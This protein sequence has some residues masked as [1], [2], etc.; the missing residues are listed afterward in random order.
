MSILDS[1]PTPVL[2]TGPMGKVLSLNQA[3][4]ALISGQESDWLDGSMDAFFPASVQILLQTQIWPLLLHQGKVQEVYLLI[5]DVSQNEIP[6]LASCQRQLHEG[7]DAYFWVF[8]VMLE[9]SLFEQE[10]LSSRT[11][12]RQSASELKLALDASARAQAKL[13]VELSEHEVAKQGLKQSQLSLAQ[14]T[15]IAKLGVWRN[16]RPDPVTFDSIQS[17]WSEEMYVLLGYTEQAVPVPTAAAFLARVHPDDRPLLLAVA[18]KS[19]AEKA[20]WQTEYRLIRPDGIECLVEES[21]EYIFEANGDVKTM[22]GVVKDVTEKKKAELYLALHRDQLEELVRHRTSELID[23]ERETKSVNRSLHMLSRC[24]MVVVHATDEH[25]LLRDLCQQICECGNFLLAWVGLVPKEL[26]SALVPVAQFGHSSGYLKSIQTNWAIEQATSR[27]PIFSALSTGQTQLNRNYWND[28]ASILWRDVGQADHARSLIALPLLLDEQ[29]LGVLTIHSHHAHAFLASEVT[30]LEELT[31]NISFGLKSLRERQEL[32]R[33]QLKLEDLVATRTSE[34]S[35]AKNTADAANLAKGSFLATMSHELR[36][37]LNAIIGLSSLMVETGLN[38]RQKD[39]AKKIQLSGNTL[40]ALIDDILDFSKIES[41]EAN[42]HLAPFSLNELLLSVN[43]IAFI[44][45]GVL[46]IEFLFDVAMDIPDSLIGDELR[47]R[48]IVLNLCSNAIKFTHAGEIVLSVSSLQLSET[49]VTLQFSIRDTGIGIPLDKQSSI[50]D[51]FTQADSSIS[52][53]FGGTGLGLSISARLVRLMGGEI[54]VTSTLGVGSE[55]SFRVKMALGEKIQATVDTHLPNGLRVLIVDDH[56]LARDIQTRHCLSLG[57]LPTAMASGPEGLQELR[58]SAATACPYDIL[59]LDWHMP[60]MDGLEMLQLA[61]N[62]TDF[63][64]PLVIL[65]SPAYELAQADTAAAELGLDDLVAKPLLIDAL[66]DAVMRAYAGEFTEILPTLGKPDRPLS[67]VRLLVAED[68]ILNQEVIEQ[69]LTQAGAC[70]VMVSN[71]LAAVA[72]LRVKESNF[73]VVLMDIQMP[74]MD[75]YTATRVIR[76]ELG[77]LDLPIIAVTANARPDDREKTQQAGMVGHLVKPL[78]VK[79]LLALVAHY[80]KTSEQVSLP[81]IQSEQGPLI[82]TLSN[83]KVDRAVDTS[84]VLA[85]FGGQE[86]KCL[87]ILQKFCTQ[88]GSDGKKLRQMLADQKLQESIALLHELCG[89]TGFLIAKPLMT[90]TSLAEEALRLGQL[91][92]LPDLLDEIDQ[93]LEAVHSET[94][95]FENRMAQRLS[96]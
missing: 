13:L 65:M 74:V 31:R 27:G 11:A 82:V 6:V 93:A 72:A 38:L 63:S 87:E 17:M 78:N 34:L 2:M 50:F 35:E 4:L 9:R 73:D 14:A 84:A 57:W 47:L 68:N 96:N 36:T 55:F 80:C 67:G 3:L 19:L 94:C 51:E 23:S 95:E 1:L 61:Q 21:G 7:S 37:P 42:L 54:R 62:L 85:M 20:S 70:V 48:Q 83:P 32:D 79:D 52:R 12:A 24:N 88:H 76:E 40:C 69:V 22:M 25:Q 10:M 43:E 59:L 81:P 18:K 75:G 41:G 16:E 39:Y 26:N 92:L 91:N 77:L 30:L 53:T 64:L 44:N 60:G 58:R 71:G 33:Y 90:L 8:S 28:P 45:T 56:P 15:R 86:A 29:L 66:K 5:H 49:E 46:S 89:I